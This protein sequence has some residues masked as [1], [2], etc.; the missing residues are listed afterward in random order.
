MLELQVDVTVMVDKKASVRCL[1]P[2]GE[3]VYD[4]YTSQKFKTQLHRFN[5]ISI[6]E[7]LDG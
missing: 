2:V 1:V 4:S 6:C 5:L 7:R 3:D